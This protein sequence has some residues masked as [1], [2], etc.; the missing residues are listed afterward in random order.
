MNMTLVLIVAP[1]VAAFLLV[2]LYLIFKSA[3]KKSSPLLTLAGILFFVGATT[4][5]TYFLADI[6]T[7]RLGY[8]EWRLERQFFFRIFTDKLSAS[9]NLKATAKYMQS[10]E[11]ATNLKPTLH[12]IVF[13]RHE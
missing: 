13:P 8:K 11:V 7:T 5:G 2:F 3:Q 12:R 9:G 4:A 1:Q 6:R 10:Q